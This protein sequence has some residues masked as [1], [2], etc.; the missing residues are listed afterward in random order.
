VE[1]LREFA[2]HGIEIGAHTRS[3]ANLGE[4][5]DPATL[6]S[7]IVGSARDLESWLERPVRYFAFPY[8][9]PENTSQVAVDVIQRH[10]FEGFCTAYGAWN[11]PNSGGYHVRRIHADPGLE[12]LC[13]WLS[14][15]ARK[16]H[17][18]VQLPFDEPT[19]TTSQRST[20][21]ELVVPG[22]NTNHNLFPFSYEFWP[23]LPFSG[24]T[25]L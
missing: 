19:P 20:P 3:H 23:T 9:L 11:W 4:I 25:R 24:Q 18:R 17:E 6:E 14:F 22:C 7:E 21:D 13:N 10:G 8:G 2:G 12:K 15:D 1:Q 16:L 5:H